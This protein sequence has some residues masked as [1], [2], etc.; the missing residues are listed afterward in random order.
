MKKIFIIIALFAN[1]ITYGQIHKNPDV[2]GSTD[3]NTSLE[4]SFTISITTYT[5]TGLIYYDAVKLSDTTGGTS[6]QKKL[7]EHYGIDINCDKIPYF[8]DKT[9]CDWFKEKSGNPEGSNI[10]NLLTSFGNTNVTYFAT[11]LSQ[12]LAERTK[13]ELNEAF[14]NGMR[15]KL[16][17]YPELRVL[18][19]QTWATMQNIDSYG[20]AYI[21]QLLKYAFETDM[22]TLPQNF[23]NIKTVNYDCI[24]IDNKKDR[25]R[26]EDRKTKL[27]EF[28]KSIEGQWFS[29]GLH[30]LNE[31]QTA[32]N[33]AALLKSIAEYPEMG[34][35]KDS[36]KSK[37]CTAELNMLSFIELS[38]VISQSLLSND[39][40]HV[41]IT[42]QQLDTLFQP[43]VFN[44]YLGLLLAKELQKDDLGKIKFYI[45]DATAISFA[46]ILTDNCSRIK[47]FM[48]LIRNIYTI[49][50]AG[51]EAVNKMRLAIENSGNIDSR[52]LIDFY[53]TLSNSIRPL[54]NG[55]RMIDNRIILPKYEK[56]DNILNPAVDLYYHILDKQYSAAVFDAY[57]L[58]SNIKDKEGKDLPFLKSFLKYG[59]LIADV[60]NAKS[61]DE[62]K[63]AIAATAMPVGSSAMKRNSRFSVMLQAYVGGYGGAVYYK[64][65]LNRYQTTAAYGIFAPVG[66]SLNAG[67]KRNSGAVSF[68]FQLLDLGSLVNFYLKNGDNAVLPNDYKVNLIDI[69]SPGF[70]LGYLFPRTPLTAFIGGNYIPAFYKTAE[71]TYKG[72]CRWQVGVA[73]DIPMYKLY[74]SDK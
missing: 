18:F 31:A 21:P 49:F 36:L 39:E 58:M 11:G 8:K 10:S 9:Y 66:F 41:W 4:Q 30:T 1:V 53:R 51:N 29:F 70:Q 32:K 59:M 52:S 26:C 6:L 5:T 65:S 37:K 15:D 43:D 24:L 12:F 46:D 69:F 28:F 20:Y 23:N 60:A 14:L 40:K 67:G 73:V 2:F 19:P 54:A 50:S 38:N 56:I 22:L 72:G 16:K 25:D 17:A 64:D 62:V 55:I 48:T 3:N 13:E 33:P 45:N 74:I 71:N 57:V 63:K 42:K 7:L 44:I 34:T 27:N 68:N 61:S 35:L 47:E